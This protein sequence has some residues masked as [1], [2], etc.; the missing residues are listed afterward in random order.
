[1]MIFP[2]LPSEIND[3][4]YSYLPIEV[5]QSKIPAVCKKWYT[6]SL[7]QLRYDSTRLAF[8]L[9]EAYEVPYD[10]KHF[11][12]SSSRNVF[13]KLIK[14]PFKSLTFPIAL[15]THLE[16]CTLQF[17]LLTPPQEFK[18][19]EYTSVHKSEPFIVYYYPKNHSF[20]FQIPKKK[21]KYL[22]FTCHMAMQILTTT[23]RQDPFILPGSAFE[24][25]S[26]RILKDSILKTKIYPF[27]SSQIQ[28]EKGK[29]FLKGWKKIKSPEL[30]NPA[31][32][33]MLAYLHFHIASH[34]ESIA[35]YNFQVLKGK[36]IEEF[37]EKKTFFC[38]EW[39]KLD[40][41]EGPYHFGYFFKLV[42]KEVTWDDGQRVWTLQWK[43]PCRSQTTTFFERLRHFVISQTTEF[44]VSEMKLLEF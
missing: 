39:G 30:Y 41:E 7:Q 17:D 44:L 13:R 40:K 25:R 29:K 23:S 9:L 15:P 6:P 1:M 20:R 33:Y 2:G 43:N 12:N 27:F 21:S 28:V 32:N 18:I 16:E 14:Y 22:R 11:M 19:F 26:A 31:V 8:N 3:K 36:T 37:K 4:I 38:N 34:I 10:Q 24:M 5:K 35:R 42:A